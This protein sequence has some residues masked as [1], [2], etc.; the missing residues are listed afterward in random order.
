MR[1]DDN[2]AGSPSS[3]DSVHLESEQR[4]QQQPLTSAVD[5][6]LGRDDARDSCHSGSLS[7]SVGAEL[8]KIPSSSVLQDN[9]LPARR[10]VGNGDRYIFSSGQKV[11]ICLFCS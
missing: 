9:N 10:F 7:Y 1:E 4:S 2:G 5:Q 3:R 11:K 8:K 6:E